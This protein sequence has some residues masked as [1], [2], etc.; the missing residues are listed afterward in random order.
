MDRHRVRRPMALLIGAV[1][2]ELVEDLKAE[3]ANI[4]EVLLAVYEMGVHTE[5]GRRK[6]LSAKNGLL[7]HLRRED[8]QLYPALLKAAEDDPIVEDAMAY[9]QEDMVSVSN[10]ALAFFDKYA[11]ET[12]AGGFADDFA[13]LAAL[14]TQRIRKEEA[15]IYRMYDQLF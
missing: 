4:V 13:T 9:F 15:V 6:L 2:T 5:A 11:D 1:M 12:D 10:L 8:D 7:A 14:L 3:H